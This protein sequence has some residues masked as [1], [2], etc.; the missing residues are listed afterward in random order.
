MVFTAYQGRP[1]IRET[2]T[3]K[4]IWSLGSKIISQNDPLSYLIITIFFWVTHFSYGL[5]MKPRMIWVTFMEHYQGHMWVVGPSKMFHLQEGLYE[6]ETSRSY[7]KKWEVG[8]SQGLAAE[9]WLVCW[10]ERS[11]CWERSQCPDQAGPV[12]WSA[13]TSSLAAPYLDLLLFPEEQ[14]MLL[15]NLKGHFL[16]KIKSSLFFNV[17]KRTLNNRQSST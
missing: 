17:T 14:N 13:T 7:A 8:S 4:R 6:V 15:L 5:C 3:M 2:M 12:S 10:T 9:G 1:T 11:W 16:E